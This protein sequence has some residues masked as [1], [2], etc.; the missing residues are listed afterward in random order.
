MQ[1]ICFDLDGTL[2]HF[3]RDYD[4]I[5]AE[6]FRAV[7]GECSD[8][9]L[10]TYSET[11][12]ELF[13]RQEPQPYRRAFEAVDDDIDHDALVETLLEREVDACEPP[14]GA[15]ADLA[16]LGETHRLGVLTDGV[17]EWQRRKLSANGLADY[18]DAVLVSYEVGAHKP[19]KEA[20][21]AVERR[22][23]AESYAMV[24]DAD[25]DVE[26]ARTAGWATYRYRGEGFGDLPEGIAWP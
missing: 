12:F 11:F 10:E 22:I 14:E 13:G 9:W 24:G 4:E 25:A 17:E 1:A 15:H 19:S 6:G 23:P 26:G 8:E 21:S 5:L 2:L 16:R 7:T 3:P 20:F 18:F